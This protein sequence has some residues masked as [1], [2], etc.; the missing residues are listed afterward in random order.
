MTAVAKSTLRFARR[1]Y[2]L[3]GVLLA[4]ASTASAGENSWTLAG[5]VGGQIHALAT[6]PTNPDIAVISTNLGLARSTDSGNTWTIVKNDTQNLPYDISFDPS[7]PNRV[8]ATD[9]SWAV[10]HL[11][12][13]FAEAVESRT[14]LIGCFID[15]FGD[16]P[17]LGGA[18]M[19]DGLVLAA[20]GRMFDMGRMAR[21][22][23]PVRLLEGDRP[24]LPCPSCPSCPSRPSSPCG[25][26]E[27]RRK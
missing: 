10:E 6:H 19:H 9:G 2:W 27:V 17:T 11:G 8:V 20:S 3:A 26:L 14:H 12:Q 4:C 13:P 5:P 23:R 24:H 15:A 25:L 21:R 18:P 7:S 16:H 1:G 22:D